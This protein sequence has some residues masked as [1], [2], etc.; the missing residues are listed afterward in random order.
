MTNAAVLFL[1]SSMN[2]LRVV[3]W[4]KTMSKLMGGT[5]EVVEY[6]RDKTI[7]GVNKDYPLPSV[8]K[9]LS[10][11]KRTRIKLKFSRINVYLRDSFKCQYCAKRFVTEDL[12]YDHV[13]PKSRG[14]K[15]CWENIVTCCVPCN[16]RKANRTPEEAGLRI[17]TKPRKPFFL[18]EVDV[19][20]PDGKIPEEWK[21]YWFTQLDG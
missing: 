19:A 13:F 20:M 8:V 10:H 21:P 7:R 2:P 6:S 4:R 18:P 14:G 16:L 12:T 3:S 9:V 5:V 1:D 15:G 11:F 17:L